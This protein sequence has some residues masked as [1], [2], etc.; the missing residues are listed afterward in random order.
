M[1]LTLSR[2]TSN[3]SFSKTS[4]VNVSGIDKSSK[5]PKNKKRINKLE[6]FFVYYIYLDVGRGRA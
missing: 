6:L 3:L 5:H 1:K 4:V 2:S